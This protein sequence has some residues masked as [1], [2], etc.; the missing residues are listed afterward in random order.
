MAYVVMANTKIDIDG[1]PKAS[2]VR[3]INVSPDMDRCW[4]TFEYIKRQAIV[5][6]LEA[7]RVLQ[8]KLVPKGMW[9]SFKEE[10][11]DWVKALGGT[12]NKDF[13]MSAGMRNKNGVLICL[14]EFT[15]SEANELMRLINEWQ[16][17]PSSKKLVLNGNFKFI[18]T[19]KIDDVSFERRKFDIAHQ[20]RL[21]LVVEN[22]SSD[23]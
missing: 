4:V 23:D 13:T 11:E 17:E 19:D 16:K 6:D 9:F 5:S 12:L 14:D 18:E 10:A 20:D 15:D 7:F 8:N 3:I 1:I 22:I 2:T 21:Q